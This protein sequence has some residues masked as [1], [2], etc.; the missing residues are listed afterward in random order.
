MTAISSC[1]TKNVAR[2][3]TATQIDTWMAS[4][5]TPLDA[6]RA[7]DGIKHGGLENFHMI[8]T[9]SHISIFYQTRTHLIYFKNNL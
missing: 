6:S 1:L 7:I 3:G 9:S 8:M 2:L 5:V 4:G